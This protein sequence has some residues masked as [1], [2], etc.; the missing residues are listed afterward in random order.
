MFLPARS[1]LSSILA[2]ANNEWSA[3]PLTSPE[4]M[5]KGLSRSHH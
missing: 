2:V 3:V 1:V 4:E 5:S